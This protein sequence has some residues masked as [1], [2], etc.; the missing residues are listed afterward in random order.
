[1]GSTRNIMNPSSLVIGG[2]EG[3][4]SGSRHSM[5]CARAVDTARTDVAIMWSRR[6]QASAIGPEST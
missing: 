2:V 4:E 1:M 3:V 6:V 5:T